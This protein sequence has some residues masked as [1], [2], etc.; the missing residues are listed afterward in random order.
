[1]VKSRKRRNCHDC[2]AEDINECESIKVH[3]PAYPT[4]LPCRICL[5]NPESVGL[6]DMYSENW[7]FIM[8]GRGKVE[9]LIEDPTKQEL[10]LL[11]IVE[12][13]TVKE[14]CE[15]EKP[16]QNLVDKQ[17]C[18]YYINGKCDFFGKECDG[19]CIATDPKDW[20]RGLESLV[21]ELKRRSERR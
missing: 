13:V 11:D 5:R 4:V 14:C 3:I 21:K 12:R 6:Y 7:T 8:L 16:T 2:G 18:P 15:T 20:H 10:K 17:N 9:S 19:P 1:M